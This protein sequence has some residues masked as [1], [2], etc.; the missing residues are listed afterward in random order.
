MKIFIFKDINNIY[1]I[2]YYMSVESIINFI[3]NKNYIT[4]NEISFSNYFKGDYNDYLKYDKN[5]INIFKKNYENNC[6]FTTE[7]SII[8]EDD[9]NYR[10]LVYYNVENEELFW[11]IKI[12]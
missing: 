4:N 6:L 12:L 1:I 7:R 8:I 2:C 11:T 3:D 9:K 5:L 10:I